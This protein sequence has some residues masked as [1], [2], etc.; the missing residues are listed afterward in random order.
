MVKRVRIFSIFALHEQKHGM[1]LTF[2]ETFDLADLRAFIT[3]SVLSG[4]FSAITFF[5]EI[6][7]FNGQVNF[8]YPQP[9]YWQQYRS[10]LAAG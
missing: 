7:A 1:R 3:E 10:I 6:E 8:A 9:R 2:T 5:T 4:L